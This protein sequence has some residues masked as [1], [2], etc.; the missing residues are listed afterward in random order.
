M[1]RKAPSNSASRGGSILAS[2]GTLL[3][4]SSVWMVYSQVLWL[5]LV[6]KRPID[7]AQERASAGETTYAGEKSSVTDTVTLINEAEDMP[8]STAAPGDIEGGIAAV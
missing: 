2:L 7:N 4:V 1:S 8:D 6:E 3:L 5:E